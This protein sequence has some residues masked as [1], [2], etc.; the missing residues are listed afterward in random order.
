MLDLTR[1][2]YA[3]NIDRQMDLK[4]HSTNRWTKTGPVSRCER[5][6]P[7]SHPAGDDGFLDEAH[8]EDTQ[9]DQSDFL[10]FL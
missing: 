6:R 3:T 9:I 4:S 7:V 1:L 10:Q 5:G 2:I 8:T